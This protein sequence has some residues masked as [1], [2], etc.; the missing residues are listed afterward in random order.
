MMKSGMIAFCNFYNFPTGLYQILESLELLFQIIRSNEKGFIAACL[1]CICLV[2]R[3]F[4]ET[5]GK[6]TEQ[7]GEIKHRHSIRTQ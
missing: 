1:T 7:P 4:L 5:V 3:V 2:E 6:Q